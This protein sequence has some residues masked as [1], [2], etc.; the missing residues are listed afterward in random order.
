MVFVNTNAYQI[1]SGCFRWNQLCSSETE[2]MNCWFQFTSEPI[3][4]SI[5][6][7]HFSKRNVDNKINN[8]FSNQNDERLMGRSRG[9]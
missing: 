4:I 1:D 9:R 5:K 6:L 8:M 3:S 2:H 7:P